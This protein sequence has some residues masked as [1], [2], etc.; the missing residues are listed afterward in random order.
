MSSETLLT[1]LFNAPPV[2]AAQ[3]VQVEEPAAVRLHP[4]P[5]PEETLAVEAVFAQE[6]ESQVVLGMLGVWTG[7]LVLHDLAV[8]HFSRPED[9]EEDEPDPRKKKRGEEEEESV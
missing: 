8:E 6:R 1:V 9:E 2:E 4:D 5:T 7:A 3:Q